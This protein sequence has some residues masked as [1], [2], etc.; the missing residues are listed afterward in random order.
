MRLRTFDKEPFDNIGS[1]NALPM[2]L[3]AIKEGQQFLKILGYA[4]DRL[5]RLGLPARLPLAK[6]FQGRLAVLGLIDE[7]GLL[8]TGA[9]R[10]FEFVFQIAQLVSPAALM[11]QARPQSRQS[12]NEAWLSVS[13]YQLESRALKAAPP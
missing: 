10:G 12:F 7:L 4:G 3:R 8:Q 1:A 5:G 11:S 9:L 13:G 2:L 6:R